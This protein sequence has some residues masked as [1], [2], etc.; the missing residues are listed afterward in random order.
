MQSIQAFRLLQSKGSEGEH[1]KT[2][3]GAN[4]SGTV[5]SDGGLGGSGSAAGVGSS[6]GRRDEGG[7]LLSDGGLGDGGLGDGSLGDG[8]LGD[9]GSLSDSGGLGSLAGGLSSLAG[10]LSSRG[11]GGSRGAGRADGGAESLDRGEDLV[12]GNVGAAG[13]N[14]T[15]G[16]SALDG[17]KVLAD[18]GVVSGVAAGVLLNGVVEASDGALGD[19]ASRLGGNR[20]GEGEGNERVLHLEGFVFVSVLEGELDIGAC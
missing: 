7:G 16:G 13:L 11:R 4:G 9:G 12:D 5:G 17:V 8:S 2:A 14:D 19:V 18:T 1:G 3:N 10:G 15:A 6:S 20:G